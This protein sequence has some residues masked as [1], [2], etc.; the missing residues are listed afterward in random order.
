MVDETVSLNYPLPKDSYIAFDA[1]TLRQ[2]IVKRLNEQGIFTDQNY[3][4]SNL[5]CIIDIVSYTFNTLMY[6]LNKTST[7]SMF[8]EAQLYENINRIVNLLGYKPLGYQTCL[9]SFDLYVNELYNTVVYTI[10]RYSYV[11]MNDII[12]SLNQDITFLRNYVDNN[13]NTLQVIESSYTKF[14]V[15][16]KFKEYGNYTATGQA[17]ELFTFAFLPKLYVDHYNIHVYVKSSKTGKWSMYESAQSLYLENKE[18]TKYEIRLNTENSYEIKFG[19]DFNGKK[20]QQGDLVRIFYLVSDG[21][22]GIVADGTFIQTPMTR[23]NS[24]YHQEI[25]NDLLPTSVILTDSQMMLCRATNIGNSTFPQAAETVEQIKQSAPNAFK[26]QYRLANENDYEV[27]IKS[28]FYNLITDVYVVNNTDYMSTYVKYYY[29]LGLTN[30]TLTLRALFNQV[31]FSNS[32][33]FNNMYIIVV[34]KTFNSSATYLLPSQKQ[35][36]KSSVDEIKIATTETVFVDPVYIAFALGTTNETYEM[37][38]I[39]TEEVT[40]VRITKTDNT[41]R[42]NVSIQIEARNIIL[43]YFLH[44]NCTLGQNVNI[45]EIERN[46]LSIDG[47]AKVE[48]YRIDNPVI[49][50][51]GLSFYAWNP[52]YTSDKK[53]ATG[54]IQLLNFQYPYLKDKDTL[55]SKIEVI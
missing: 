49:K 23:Y 54:N 8:T 34:P 9:M 42:T 20:L 18:A 29:D 14:F 46:I 53:T 25:L 19:D 4:G 12:Y 22:S 21:E 37:F 31:L 3:I 39:T 48:T 50:Y 28:N 52:S 5:A 2:L 6:Y 36:I 13:R 7:E 30:P 38:D 43:S 11:K 41:K 10:P 55:D 32:C 47:V 33:N 15:Q 44:P 40:R 35:L 51:S 1:L 16:G 26:S 27:F 45:R 17:N 24:V